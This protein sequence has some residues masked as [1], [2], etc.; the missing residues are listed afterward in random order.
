MSLSPFAGKPAPAELLVDL[1]RLVTAYYTGQPDASVSTQRVSFGTS[2]HRGS[3]FELSFNEWHVLAISQAICLYRQAN[4]IDGPLFLGFDTHALSTPAS[5][6][7]LEVLA[8]NGVQVMIAENDEYTPTPAISHA[9]ICYNR[10]RTHGLA[11]GIVITPSHNPPES[12]GFKYNPPNGGPADTHI[13]KW[14]EAKANELLAEKVLGV[15]R[16]TYEKALLADT[17]HRHDYLNTYVADLKNVIDMDAIRGAN[18]RLGVDPLGGAGVHYWSAIGEHY[19]LNLEVVNKEVDPTFRF[20]CVD[21]DGRIRMDPSSSFA[22]QGLIGLKDRFQVAFACDPDHD[23]HGIVTPTGGLLAPNNYLAVSIDYLFQNRPQW[24]ADAAI[25]KTVVSSGMIDRVAKR[26]GRRLYEVPVGFKWFADGLFDGS[27]GFGGE[28]S[29]GASFL[30]KDGSVW[31][32]DKDGLIPALLAAEITA[33]KGRDPSEIYHALT[34]ELGD[35]FSTRVEAKAS[36]EQKALLGKLSPGQVKST[37]LAGET[38]QS[39]LSHAPGND[40][41]IGGLKVMTENGWF[42][43]RPSGT[44]DIYKI[45]AESFLGEDHLKRLVAEAQVLVDAAIAV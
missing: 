4:G 11:D 22:M 18:L 25:G 34:E 20:M 5:V 2:G 21:W 31:T 6:T 26:L 23:R 38:I 33:R 36:P 44:E 7:A 1:P 27:L 39:I 32:T 41:A 45:Y 30:R 15:T 24:R 17:T 29:A 10:G 3:S 13:T 42:A 14:I 35:P 37:E 28:E 8:A 16:M 43:A 12:G 40:Q 9:I 19:N